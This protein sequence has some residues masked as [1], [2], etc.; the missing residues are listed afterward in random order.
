MQALC[1]RVVQ[2]PFG[3]QREGREVKDVY[4]AMITQPIGLDND[5]DAEAYGLL[6]MVSL[7]A[8]SSCTQLRADTL[9]KMLDPNPARRATL[10]QAKAHPW[11]SDM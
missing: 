10:E 2:L 1:L 11:F 8:A 7:V 4:E 3:I 5:I 9:H 6:L